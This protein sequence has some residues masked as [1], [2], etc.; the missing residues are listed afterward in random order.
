MPIFGRVSGLYIRG[1]KIIPTNKL[2]TREWRISVDLEVILAYNAGQMG[3]AP[4][5]PLGKTDNPRI[6]RAV[7]EALL[8]EANYRKSLWTDA[9]PVLGEM[10]DGDTVRLQRIL[11][12]LMPE[13]ETEDE[14]EED[15]KES[16]PISP[17]LR[18]LAGGA[19]DGEALQPS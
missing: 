12:S 8:W 7:G 14:A 17:D 9:D 10:M 5:V 11:T 18:L 15:E 4:S 2:Y 3:S 6:L 19:V 13:D 1:G 16:S